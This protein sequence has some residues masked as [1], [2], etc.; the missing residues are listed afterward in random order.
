VQP[1]SA[2]E[3]PRGLLSIPNRLRYL[4]KV[5]EEDVAESPYYVSGRSEER[6]GIFEERT[7][8]LT[9]TFRN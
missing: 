2:S 9:I 8:R 5:A 6:L 4:W 3:S 1:F 7:G